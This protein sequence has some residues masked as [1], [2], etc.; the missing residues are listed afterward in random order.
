MTTITKTFL[1]TITL[2]AEQRA[3]RALRPSFRSIKLPV[4]FVDAP[5]VSIHVAGPL[6]LPFVCGVRAVPVFMHGNHPSVRKN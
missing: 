5:E 1:G 4:R 6:R 2:S 3:L